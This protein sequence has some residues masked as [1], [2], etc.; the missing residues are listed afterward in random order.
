MVREQNQAKPLNSNW[1]KAHRLAQVHC[2][3]NHVSK[4]PPEPSKS[5]ISCATISDTG[6]SH[7][8]QTL[9][10]AFLVP[11]DCCP[12][13]LLPSAASSIVLQWMAIGRASET[14]WDETALQPNRSF[15]V[16][17]VSPTWN[18]TRASGMH[19][20]LSSHSK[21]PTVL[22]GS[23]HMWIYRKPSRLFQRSCWSW[24][25]SQKP[26]WL[27]ESLSLDC[28]LLMRTIWRMCVRTSRNVVKIMQPWKVNRYRLSVC[29]VK[30]GGVC[31]CKTKNS[32][33]NPITH[34]K[35]SPRPTT[36][37]ANLM[38]E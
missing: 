6:R 4:A 19:W 27:V 12:H 11:S 5:L 37:V 36:A 16:I 8:K 9:L 3:E 28:L 24:L 17:S 14:A 35:I 1:Q 10:A 29:A 7:H 20:K 2:A 32:D 31:Y 34:P 26:I 30:G 23:S 38:T 21:V 18:H 13:C 22:M 25:R 33:T 15:G